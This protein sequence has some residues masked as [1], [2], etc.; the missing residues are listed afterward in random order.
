M[1]IE[2]TEEQN[3]AIP[4]W[5]EKWIAEGLRTDEMDLGKF[6]AAAKKCY[7]FA[8]IPFPKV[9]Q[10]QSPIVGAL[11]APIAA[12]MI[13]SDVYSAIRSAVY[14]TVYSVVR[15]AVYSP[16]SST[17]GS[18]VVRSTV[19][20][21]VDSAVSSAVSSAVGSAVDSAVHSAVSSASK[22]KLWWHNWI[23]GQFWVA[24]VAF[25]KFCREIMKVKY[26]NDI[27]NRAIAYEVAQTSVNYWWPNKDFVI[28]CNRPKKINRNSSG[29][30]HC[31]DGMAIEYRDGWGLWMLNGVKVAQDIVMTP[32]NEL[33]TNLVM[34]E[35]N[36]EVRREIVRKIG[37]E[38]V[39]TKLKAKVL[40][41]QG[42]YE[43]LQLPNISGM[44]IIPTYLKMKN[45]SIGV[46]HV[47]G[48]P[49]E[50]KTVQQALNRRAGKLLKAGD[51][52]PEQLT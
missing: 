44:S 14:S 28:V 11:S 24:W 25:E 30:L 23:G 8:G 47:E 13:Y 12:N 5:V 50:V 39:L 43:L 22:N 20:S 31:I 27:T 16:V 38:R 2:L 49:P 29:Q 6:T 45:P 10:V 7:D 21:A 18:T 46:W 48:V 19:Y 32:A 35:K 26:C 41:K 52:K 36:A 3:A 33:D 17:V 37:I 15:S 1:I 42:D 4:A 51:W 9:I 34:T 40:D